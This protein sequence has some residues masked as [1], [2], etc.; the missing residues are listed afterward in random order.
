M[1][2]DAGVA[3]LGGVMAADVVALTMVIAWISRQDPGF[4][5]Q[6]SSEFDAYLGRLGSDAP[7]PSEVL[8]EARK[9]LQLMLA[10]VPQQKEKLSLRRRF[11]NWLNAS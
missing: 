1:K 10:A 2:F 3:G 6:V 9:M 8:Q 7:L 5:R 11:L 4:A